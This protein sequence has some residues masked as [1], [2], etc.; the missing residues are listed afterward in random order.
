MG[1]AGGPVAMTHTEV[2]PFFGRST[3]LVYVRSPTGRERTLD[4]IE[5]L[6]AQTAPITATGSDVALVRRMLLIDDRGELVLSPLVETIQIRHFSLGQSFHEFGLDRAALFDGRGGDLGLEN[7]LFMLFMGHGDV[8]ETPDI[9]TRRTTIPDICKA[10][11]FH[12]LSLPDAANTQDIISYSR[13]PSPLPDNEQPIL[14]ATNLQDEARTVMEW[15]A[16]MGHGNHSKACG[17]KQAHKK[18][19]RRPIGSPPACACFQEPSS[20]T[21]GRRQAMWRFP[22]RLRACRCHQ[23]E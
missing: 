9:P 3:F 23:R 19:Q 10:C 1:R 4:F 18:Q 13:R 5:S 17:I 2:F 22:E 20:F 8:F 14:F 12:D 7:E 21:Y 11:H 15:N 6:S 16:D